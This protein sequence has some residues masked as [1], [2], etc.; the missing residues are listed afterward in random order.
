MFTVPDKEFTVLVCI[1]IFIKNPTKFLHSC[2]LL[3]EDNLITLSV[4]E[5]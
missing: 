1:L 2:I 4:T 3:K 5:S